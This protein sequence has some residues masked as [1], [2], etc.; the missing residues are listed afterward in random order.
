MRLDGVALTLV[1]SEVTKNLIPANIV[2]FHQIDQFSTIIVLKK[3]HNSY[4]LFFSL[5]PDH[6]AF[7]L[8]EII[9]P[10]D[11]FN[12]IF[13]KQL[14]SLLKGGGILTIEQVSFDRI[15]EISLEQYHKFGPASKYK[16]I[17]EFMGKHSNAVLIDEKGFIKTALKQVGS[18]INRYREI[19]PGILYEPPPASDK[20]HPL[21]IDKER[22]LAIVQKTCISLQPG[23]LWQFFA[24]RFLGIDSTSAREIVALLK[25]PSEQKLTELSA[26]QL[27]FLWDGF[28]K[29]Q[30]KIIRH[31]IQPLL[32]IDKI[33]GKPLDYSLIYPLKQS[34]VDYL[35]FVGVSLCLESFYT[36]ISKEEE[37]LKLYQVINK[38]L[39][40]YQKKLLVKKDYLEKRSRELEECEQYQKEGELLKANLWNIKR[41]MK[42]ITLI[43]YSDPARP[44]LTI[45]LNPDL[46][47]LQNALQLFTKYKKLAPDRKGL[48]G[49]LLENQKALK[50]LKELYLEL[51]VSRDSINSLSS[52]YQKLAD[53]NIVKTK[54]ERTAKNI[55][56]KIPVPLKF[57]SVDGWTILVGKNNQQNEYILTHLSRG[58]DFWLHNEIRPGAHVLLKNHQNLPSPPPSTLSLAAKLAG[59]YSKVKDGETASIIY[60]LRKYV[61]K[62]KDAKVGKVIYSQEKSVPVRINYDEIKREI[63]KITKS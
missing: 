61:R 58:N 36:K 59:Y 48:E 46:S 12:S 7:F 54:K 41:G 11:N 15:I 28:S 53:S 17:L 55:G 47:P 43:D 25:F 13:T 63:K 34:G 42:Q 22:F 52:L 26:H 2:G 8:S 6:M 33:S 10:Q 45:P 38:S 24:N 56:K 40:K 57:I 50:Q 3:N 23:Y 31:D 4:K 9:S 44:A 51:R 20:Y 27:I 35:S 21:T 30:E 39:H 19:K 29:F 32:L 60:T 37:R 62:P 16:L 18:D 49:Q 1:L 14:N 5:R